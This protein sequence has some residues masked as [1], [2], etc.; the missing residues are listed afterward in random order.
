MQI[1][2]TIT[3]KG[4]L[5]YRTLDGEYIARTCTICKRVRAREFFGSRAAGGRS[6]AVS[7]WDCV[8][9]DLKANHPPTKKSSKNARMK[10][11]TRKNKRRTDK[12]I[13][14]KREEMYPNGTVAC[15]E[16][17]VEKPFEEYFKRRT[18]PSGLTY[19]CK[20]CYRK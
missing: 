1:T 4:S 8:Y 3:H 16:C 7:C 18:N 14:L 19:K 20:S 9:A 13:R 6:P 12:Q 15:S 17:K 10:R 2:K 5:I 11:Y